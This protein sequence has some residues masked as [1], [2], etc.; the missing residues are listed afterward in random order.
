M[1]AV[2]DTTGFSIFP[3]YI[4]CAF[5]LFNDIAIKNGYY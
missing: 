5:A 4:G 1:I 3:V 2:M